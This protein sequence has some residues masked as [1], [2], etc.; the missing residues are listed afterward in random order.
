[1]YDIS[2]RSAAMR[3]VFLA[4]LV[5]TLAPAQAEEA[6]PADRPI[7]N[8]TFVLRHMYEVDNNKVLS[9]TPRRMVLGGRDKNSVTLVAQR[10]KCTYEIQSNGKVGL[11]V[12]FS[13]VSSQYNRRCDGLLCTMH[14]WAAEGGVCEFGN[15]NSHC[16][17]SLQIIGTKLS[18]D[19][20]GALKYIWRDGCGPYVK[21]DEAPPY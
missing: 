9:V 14:I 15:P 5:L 4:L 3:F 19:V 16:Y 17:P 12:D 11:R 6:N 10:D 20:I 1:M 13:R 18:D 21:P 7:L 2:L 8:A